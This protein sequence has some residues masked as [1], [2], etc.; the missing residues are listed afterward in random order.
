[1]AGD[2]TPDIPCQRHHYYGSKTTAEI[3]LLT[4]MSDGDIVW[5]TSIKAMKSY[6]Q[7]GLTW[8][9]IGGV[10]VGNTLDQAYDQGGAGAGRLINA[11]SGAVQVH[12]AGGIESEG[13][14]IPKDD[15]TQNLGSPTKRW[16]NIYSGDVV[17][18]NDWIITELTDDD[19]YLYYPGGVCI[20]NIRGEV[21]LTITDDGL[22]FKGVKIA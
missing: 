17:L 9:V 10:G 4:G 21:I 2:E 5:D 18:K 22:F 11:D 14:I 3:A 6:D 15:N 19:G 20:K 8:V 13:D 12:G 7:A 16:N 1:V